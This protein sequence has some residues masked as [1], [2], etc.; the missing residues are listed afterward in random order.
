VSRI[1]LIGGSGQLGTEIRRRWTDRDLTAPPHTE[2][3]LEDT[4]ALAAAIARVE[5]SAVVNCAAFHNVDRCE[6]EPERALAVNALA[7]ER[8]ARACRDRDVLF[9]TVS[10]DYVFDGSSTRP[11]VEDDPV[12]PI[13]AYGVS[14]LAGELLVETVGS[15]ALV[16]RT[17][18]VY[19]L[20]PSAG[21][22]YTFV[23]R[24]IAL[25]RAKDPLR[26]V[27]D[28]SASPTFAGH[29]AEAMGALLERGAT[30]LY[31]AA[32]AG[33]VSWYDFACEALRQ[34]GIDYAIEPIS[35]REWKMAARRPAFSALDS[36]KLR[37]LG[38]EMPSWREGIASYLRL[39]ES[40]QALQKP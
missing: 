37:A 39:S 6:A 2:V 35:A 18:G 22:G 13:S 23:D 1:L 34:A 30:G 29:L 20:R 8:A 9:V 14:K 26:I 19:G 40:S 11:Y 36:G 38:F 17:C 25:A 27:S 3:D 32:N 33:P 5:P 10:S 15:R 12:H 7:V 16:V 31:H 24:V 4:E 21:K 28:V